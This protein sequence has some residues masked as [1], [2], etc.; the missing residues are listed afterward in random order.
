MVSSSYF[1]SLVAQDFAC[2]GSKATRFAALAD[3][4]ISRNLHSSGHVGISLASIL[5]YCIERSDWPVGGRAQ[6]VM[7]LQL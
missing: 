5:F 4:S 7:L 3:Y 2:L 1:S 6:F